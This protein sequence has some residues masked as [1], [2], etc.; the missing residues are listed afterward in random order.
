M[1]VTFNEEMIGLWADGIKL[2]KGLKGK[3]QT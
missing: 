3:K 1:R 2:I